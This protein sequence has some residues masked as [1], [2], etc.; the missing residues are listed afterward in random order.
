MAVSN[1]KPRIFFLPILYIPPEVDRS[2]GIWEAEYNAPKAIFYLLKGDCKT[3]TLT[4]F[5][6]IRTDAGAQLTANIVVLDSL[7]K[8]STGEIK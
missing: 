4:Q 7:Y 3:A 8:N 2:W 5:A 1:L 6:L